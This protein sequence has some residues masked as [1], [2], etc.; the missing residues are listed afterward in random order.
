MSIVVDNIPKEAGSPELA[1]ITTGLGEVYQYI[2]RPK[3][4][5]ED[6]YDLTELRTIQD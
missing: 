3:K 1:P 6:K 2:V 4:G 5:Y